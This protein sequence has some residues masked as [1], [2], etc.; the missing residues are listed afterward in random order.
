MKYKLTGLQKELLL[1]IV[2]FLLSAAVCGFYIKHTPNEHPG[3]IR[4]HVIANSNSKSDQ[5]LKLKVRNEIIDFMEGQE[6]LESSR[7]YIDGNLE[8]IE[9]IADTVIS[10]RGFDYSAKAERKVTF[11]KEKSYEDLVLPAGNYETLNITLGRGSGE[12]WWCVIFPQL[13]LIGEA[14]KEQPEGKLV[15]K[16]KIKEMIALQEQETEHKDKHK[17]A[18]VK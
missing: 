5:S 7:A 16:S 3:M 15:L 18:R 17:E 9:A 14:D 1:W 12:N 13:C 2:F 6:S 10:D 11:I 8:E 4:L